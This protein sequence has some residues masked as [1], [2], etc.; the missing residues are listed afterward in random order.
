MRVRIRFEQGP[1][2]SKREGGY[3]PVAAGMASLMSPLAV[4]AGVLGVWRI[5]ADIGIAREF[6]ISDGL[7]SHWQIW[8]ML[9]VLIQ[10]AAVVLS[11]YGAQAQTEYA[12][13]TERAFDRRLL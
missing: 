9:A 13:E 6:A 3:R 11:K 5:A 12:E 7:F 10:L 4:M 8:M 2:V 1:R